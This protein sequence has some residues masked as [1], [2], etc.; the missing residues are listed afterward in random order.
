MKKII[1]KI[2]NR[3]ILVAKSDKIKSGWSSGRS[4][5]SSSGQWRKA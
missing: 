2:T 5:G 4:D 1:S 3:K